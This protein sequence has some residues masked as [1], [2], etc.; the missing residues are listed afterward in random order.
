[1]NDKEA[2]LC[3]ICKHLLCKRQEVINLALGFTQEMKCL[4]CLSK[5]AEATGDTVSFLLRMKDYVGSRQCF[6]KE[7]QKYTVESQCPSP[8]TCYPAQ[9]F[10]EEN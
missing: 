2:P 5:S 8:K 3:P 10:S 7:W 4:H 6:A 1:M 9:C